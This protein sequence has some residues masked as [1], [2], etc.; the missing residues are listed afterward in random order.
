MRGSET[1]SASPS[2]G[3]TFGPFRLDQL[4]GEGGSGVVF[5]ATFLPDGSVCALKVLKTRVA[6]DPVVLKRFE[7]EVRVATHVRHER[8]VPLL[9]SGMF[10]G[11]PYLTQR[12]LPGPTLRQ[13]IDAN[14]RLSLPEIC[15]LV[16]DIAS[17][18][19]A[20][21]AR[22]LVHRDVKPS[23][24]I[25]DEEGQ[26]LLTDFGLSRGAAYTVLT[27]PG[28]VLGTLD[29]MAPEVIRGEPAGP[30]SDIY[31]LGCVVFEAARG[32]PPFARRSVFQVGLAHLEEEPADPLEGRGDAPAYL[33]S[34]IRSALAKDPAG[35]P[36][37]ASAYAGLI[38][39]AAAETEG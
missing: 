33:A 24:I 6:D 4:L 13:L 25:Y 31:A 18:L 7:H 38:G 17:A 30:A 2:V 37:S 26:A 36:A 5:K 12:L 11:V 29:Y 23:N 21:H 15:A 16:T 35:R 28:R 9:A 10:D 14:G 27:A 22:D 39:V 32:E 34:A 19:G 3:S 8:L 1:P 20:L